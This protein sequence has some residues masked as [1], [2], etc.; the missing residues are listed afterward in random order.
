MKKVLV[1]EDN[2]DSMYL[3]KFL[4]E[5][6]GFEVVQAATG[7]EGMKRAKSEEPDLVI[8]DLMMPDMQTD[9][10]LTGLKRACGDTPVVA[11]TAYAVK[12]DREKYLK[13]GAED[14][15]EKPINPEEFIGKI[16]GFL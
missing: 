16:K 3:L 15:I 10:L 5:K 14:Y 6:N 7:R 8:T 4:L 1:I 11:V 12:G 9:E 2:E 13:M